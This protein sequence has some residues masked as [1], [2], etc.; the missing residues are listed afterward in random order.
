M[1]KQIV[2]KRFYL[3][4]LW[5]KFADH[6]ELFIEGL[7][8]LLQKSGKTQSGYNLVNVGQMRGVII[9]FL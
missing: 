6:Y 9:R 3:V 7:V 2:S 4:S 5:R 8:R 1:S